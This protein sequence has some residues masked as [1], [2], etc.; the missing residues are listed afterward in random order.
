MVAFVDGSAKGTEN[1][2]LLVLHGKKNKLNY[3]TLFKS[4]NLK[5][6]P[7]R[8]IFHSEL[9]NSLI[10]I[11]FF[12]LFGSFVAGDLKHFK[13]CANSPIQVNFFHQSGAVGFVNRQFRCR[14]TRIIVSKMSR[15]WQYVDIGSRFTRAKTSLSSFVRF[16]ACVH[17]FESCARRFCTVRYQHDLY[18]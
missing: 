4:V 7:R 14:E 5:E 10:I 9:P 17:H 12:F 8:R 6:F 1:F 2:S 18:F 3:A 15:T 16:V 11:N 13:R